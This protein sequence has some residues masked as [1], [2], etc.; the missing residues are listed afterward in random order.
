MSTKKQNCPRLLRVKIRSNSAV[1]SACPAAHPQRI[2]AW[3][4]YALLCSGCLVAL[5]AF[6][7]CRPQTSSTNSR[8]KTA[9][10][11]ERSEQRPANSHG[12]GGEA[13]ES[14]LV[15]AFPNDDFNVS[16]VQVLAD[17]DRYHGRKIQV[18]GFLV[19]RFEGTAIYLSKEDAEYGLSHNGFW[20]DFNKDAIPYEGIAGPTQY[21]R[22]YVLMEGTFDRDNRGHFSMWQG[23]IEDVDRVLVRSREE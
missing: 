3:R 21:D 15:P 14:Q 23:A 13:P 22:K 8:A 2:S 19:V 17:R 11:Q 7:A 5:P 1:R 18:E 4:R 9:V 20:V 10:T 12:I 6:L 16:M